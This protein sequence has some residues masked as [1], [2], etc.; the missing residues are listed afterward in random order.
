MLYSCLRSRGAVAKVDGVVA[1]LFLKPAHH[2]PMEP[3]ATVQAVPEKGLAG[4]AAFGTSRRQVLL[5]DAETLA[6]FDLTP[7][8]IRE[9]IT[10]RGMPLAGTPRGA[11]VHVGDVILE[12]TGDCTPCDFLES[13]RPGLRQAITG[14]RG[15][16]ARVVRGGDLNVGAAVRLES[17]DSVRAPAPSP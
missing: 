3:R 17:T 11:R 4:D 1:H 10:I 13:L 12:V 5:V 6:A 14:R 15:L 8:T 2:A 7:G 16:L 9:N